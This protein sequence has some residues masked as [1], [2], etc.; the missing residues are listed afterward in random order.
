[1]LIKAYFLLPENLDGLLDG[2]TESL[3]SIRKTHR[4]YIDQDIETSLRIRGDS[5]PKLQSAIL[6]IEWFLKDLRAQEL[7]I[8]KRYLVDIPANVSPQVAR[9]AISSGGAL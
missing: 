6:A 1:M 8:E 3:N 5:K 7:D 9:I 2:S 4:V